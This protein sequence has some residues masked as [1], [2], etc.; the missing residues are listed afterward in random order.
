MIVGDYLAV[1]ATKSVSGSDYLAAS[2]T[3]AVSGGDNHAT[4]AK[5]GGAMVITLPP[6]PQKQ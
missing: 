3:K 6:A 2:A 4:S 1:S 5:K